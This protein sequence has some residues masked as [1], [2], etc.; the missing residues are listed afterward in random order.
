MTR[1]LPALP[2]TLPLPLSPSLVL[3]K[4]IQVKRDRA[5]LAKQT[6]RFFCSPALSPCLS[7]AEHREG[8]C[9]LCK[10][11]CPACAYIPRHLTQSTRALWTARGSSSSEPFFFISSSQYLEAAWHKN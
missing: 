9:L 7:P 6:R 2:L 5:V 1:M 10:G 4:E 8:V 11:T 3:S